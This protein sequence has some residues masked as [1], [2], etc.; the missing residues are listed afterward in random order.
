MHRGF[1]YYYGE[2]LKSSRKTLYKNKCFFRYILYFLAE[3]IGRVLI[4]FNAHFNLAAVRQGYIIRKNN[5]LDFSSAFRNVGK[6]VSI[7]TY[8][9]T[10]CFEG[11]IIIAG[12]VAIATLAV[13]FGSIGYGIAKLSAAES[14]EALILIFA[15]PFAPLAGIYVLVSLLIFSPTA[16]VFAN[17]ADVSAGEAVC[18]CYRS[19]LNKGKATVF[20]TYF[21]SSLLKLLYLG[22]TSVGGYFVIQIYVPNDLITVVAI[23]WGI[24]SFLGYV[25][26]APILT[27]ANRVVK[28]HLFEDV[29]LD[30]ATAARINEKVNISICNGKKVEPSSRN[31][32]SLFEYTEDPYKIIEETQK[33]SCLLESKPSKTKKAVQP[34]E[35]KP[36]PKKKTMEE[37]QPASLATHMSAEGLKN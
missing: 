26:F 19:M 3:L 17:N 32:A 18:A 11:L 21:I 28:E 30:P 7:W 16:Y 10:L 1:K 25:A 9:L 13:I 15:A 31:L 20:L 2:G 22:A 6:R 23:A 34:V 24:V 4:V 5:K 12:I 37:P 27:L 8:I 35:V 36:Q 14:A 33:K 29:V